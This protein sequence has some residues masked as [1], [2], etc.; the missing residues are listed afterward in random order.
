MREGEGEREEG[1]GGEG[2]GDEDIKRQDGDKETRVRYWGRG[3]GFIPQTL[4]HQ[5][6]ENE[7]PRRSAKKKKGVLSLHGGPFEGER[8]RRSS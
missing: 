7:N 2:G 5:R 6:E 8:R 4:A 3:W 1:G